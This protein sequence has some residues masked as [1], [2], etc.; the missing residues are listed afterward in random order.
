MLNQKKTG[1]PPERSFGKRPEIS[2]RLTLYETISPANEGPYIIYHIL[3]LTC[4]ILKIVRAISFTHLWT[5]K[6]Q[7][8]HSNKEM[9]AIRKR[10]KGNFADLRSAAWSEQSLADLPVEVRFRIIHRTE[11]KLGHPREDRD[12]P[13]VCYICF[14][15]YSFPDF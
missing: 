1:N 4:Y 9:E 3:I 14:S 12:Y 13:P 15:R 6:C 7:R 11:I 5:T 10:K 8:L 2:C